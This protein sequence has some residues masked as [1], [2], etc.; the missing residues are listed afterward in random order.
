M[1]R[2]FLIAVL[3]IV[4]NAS[5]AQ[6]TG[7]SLSG[8][9]HDRSLPVDIQAES[10]S[11]NQDTQNAVF[12]GNAIVTQGALT[13]S[14]DEIIVSYS[15]DGSEIEKVDAIG[16]VKFS[17][18]TETAEAQNANY[19]VASGDLTMNGS[20]VLIQGPSQ[21]SGDRLEMNILTNIAQMSGKVRTRLVP[22]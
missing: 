17:N 21:I 7:L 14:A 5:W 8:A 4:A 2:W 10:L 20:V 9:T 16:N 12:S 22:R 19:E 3:A 6:S 15:A 18:S 13:L 1:K 11:V